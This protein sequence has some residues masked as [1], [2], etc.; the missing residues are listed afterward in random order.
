[1]AK[2]ESEEQIV[3]YYIIKEEDMKKVSTY[4]PIM[5]KREWVELVAEK[6]LVKM[7]LTASYQDENIPIPPIYKENVEYK[8]RYLM[9][10]FVT[11]YLHGSWEVGEGEDEWLMPIDEYDKWA[12]GHIFAQIEKFKSNQELRD[13]CFNMMNDFKDLTRQLNAEIEALMSVLNDPTSR[14]MAV[15]Q[16]SM[17]PEA[18]QRAVD[19]LNEAAAAMKEYEETKQQE[20]T[21]EDS[22]G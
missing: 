18:L 9:G 7:N 6:C 13:I 4:L 14:Q 5:A 16:M 11:L 20:Q 15:M 10:V 19:E 22:N 21:E 17:T 12:R 3:E 8:A 2:K 1:M